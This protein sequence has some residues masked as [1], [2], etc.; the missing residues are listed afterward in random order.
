[1]DIRHFNLTAEAVRELEQAELAS[2]EVEERRRMQGVRLYGTGEALATVENVV[3]ASARTIRRWATRYRN[4]GI[5]SLARPATVGNHRTLSV[6]QR[7]AVLSVLRE[8]TPQQAGVS[9]QQYWS[10]SDVARL[11]SGRY[12]VEYATPSG[13]RTLLH[14]AGLSYQKAAKV[15]RHRP[16][17]ITIADWQADAEKK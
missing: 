17:P 13:Y 6:T 16:D 15:Y 14:E 12:A 4:G 5:G 11:V 9:D 8:Q 3:Q 2:K 10:V 1:M 7:L